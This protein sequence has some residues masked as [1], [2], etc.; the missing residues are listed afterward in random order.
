MCVRGGESLLPVTALEF[1]TL[2]GS[3]YLLAGV[4]ADTTVFDAS[5]WFTIYCRRRASTEGILN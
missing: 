3:L 5:V 2:S 4:S 1:C